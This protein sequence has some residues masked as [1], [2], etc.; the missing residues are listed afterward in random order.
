MLYNTYK[1]LVSY[2]S[3]RNNLFILS[4]QLILCKDKDGK[5]GMRVNNVD[6]GIFVCLVR[7][8][9]PAALAGLRFGDQI[10]SINDVSVAGYTMEQVHKI[11]R[12]A[13]INGIKVIVRDRSVTYSF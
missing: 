5:I 1:I 12:N 13:D 2:I 10:L 9:S 4:L 8:N 7:Q 3:R 6:N 11:F